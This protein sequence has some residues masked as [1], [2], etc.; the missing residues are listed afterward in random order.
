MGWHSSFFFHPYNTYIFHTVID[1][2]KAQASRQEGITK[3][4]TNIL[5]HRPEGA[6]GKSLAMKETKG[7]GPMFQ[8]VT[9]LFMPQN[10]EI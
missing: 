8:S 7:G 6:W 10:T 9:S 4:P 5:H 3:N 2:Y 1:C